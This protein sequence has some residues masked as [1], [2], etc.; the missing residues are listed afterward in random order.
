M[1]Y[2][3]ICV[4]AF[5]IYGMEEDHIDEHTYSITFQETHSSKHKSFDKDKLTAKTLH[6][7]LGRSST[8]LNAHFG[9]LLRKKVQESKIKDEDLW[10]AVD[11]LEPDSKLSDS[12][13]VD[14]LRKE[15][16]KLTAESVEE[17]FKEKNEDIVVSKL[18]LI[19]KNKEVKAEKYKF[20]AA[21]VG[22]AGTSIL[23]LATITTL[24]ITQVTE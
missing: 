22:L 17:I 3:I 4:I 7:F 1:R 14:R 12:Q 21:L 16:R 18:Q 5:N 6:Y 24:I 20:Y 9:P 23:S 8:D 13:E 19:L 15:L 2:L 11:E 10:H